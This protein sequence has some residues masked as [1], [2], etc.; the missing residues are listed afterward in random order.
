[1]YISLFLLFWKVDSQFKNLFN[2]YQLIF[3][4][5]FNMT[6]TTKTIMLKQILYA[7]NLDIQYESVLNNQERPI[8]SIY[9]N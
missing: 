6:N 3:F 1:M 5:Q 4:Y 8:L 2:Q 7:P 9:Q